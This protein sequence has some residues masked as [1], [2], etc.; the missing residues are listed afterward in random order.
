MP[1]YEPTEKMFKEI[2]EELKKQNQELLETI[3]E[4]N[5]LLKNI[6]KDRQ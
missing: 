2:Q 3:C 1:F 4:A 5:S 6:L